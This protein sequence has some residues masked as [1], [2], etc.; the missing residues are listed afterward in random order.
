VAE[1]TAK[2]EPQA[3]SITYEDKGD[4]TLVTD[5]RLE[6][7]VRITREPKSQRDAAV[8]QDTHDAIE[9]RVEIEKEAAEN[10]G[11]PD[12]QTTVPPVKEK[13]AEPETIVVT[14]KGGEKASEPKASETKAS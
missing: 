9:A 8:D 3:G 11:S 14:A 12:P 4:H 10:E 13:D 1:K 6:D 7:A 5:A 2:S